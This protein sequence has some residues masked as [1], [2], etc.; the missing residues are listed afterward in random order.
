MFELFITIG[1]WEI[2]VANISYIEDDIHSKIHMIDGSIISSEKSAS[3]I[4]S[5]IEDLRRSKLDFYRVKLF[6]V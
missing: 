1:S 3:E 2:N 6:G 5:E 4:R